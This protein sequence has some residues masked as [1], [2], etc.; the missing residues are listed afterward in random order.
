MKD[1]FNATDVI[2][3]LIRRWWI[4]AIAAICLSVSAFIYTQVFVDPL[5]RTDGTLYVNAQRTQT[6]DVSQTNLVA[7]Q[8]LVETYKEILSRRTFLSRVASDLDNRYSVR[9]LGSMISMNPVNETEIL[10]IKVTGKV[11][12]DV[13]SI[14]HSVLTHASDELVRVVNAGSVK[15]L[16]DGQVPTS[17]VSPNV[18]QNTLIAFLIGMVLG[19]L[20]VVL[21]ELFDTRI[22]SRDDIVNKYEEP[23]LGEI[24]ELLI[25]KAGAEK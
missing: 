8:Q 21:L 16:D 2:D 18:K 5:Y 19:A 9:E 15:I 14:C 1:Q 22:K 4:L 10:E 23:L 17:P 13:Y 11:P 7:S 6:S 24:P 12:D 20:I 25:K 3:M